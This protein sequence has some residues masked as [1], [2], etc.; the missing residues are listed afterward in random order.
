MNKYVC[1]TGGT[2]GIGKA[3]A[4]CLAQSG[5]SLLLTYGSDQ[6]SAEKTRQE[7]EEGYDVKVLTLKADSTDRASIEV[8]GQFLEVNDIL[9]DAMVFNAGITCRDP[10]EEMSLEEWERVFFANVHYPVFLLQRI[11][12][13]IRKGGSVVFTGSL[14]GVHPHSVSLVYGTTKS[15]VHALVRNLVKHLTPYDIRVNG[16]APGFVDTEWQKTKPAEIRRNIE[17]KISLNRFCEP[18]ELAEVYKMLIENNYL[19]GEVIVV[20]GGYSYK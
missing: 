7:L 4:I 18:G 19:N 3:V 13:R 10:F 6:A 17:N 1:I 16:V 12:G 5:Y 14:M 20:D 2:K 9:L 15:A 8:V 11:V